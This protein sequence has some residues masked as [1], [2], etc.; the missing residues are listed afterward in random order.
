MQTNNYLDLL[1]SE[2]LERGRIQFFP[3][4]HHSPAAAVLIEQ[5]ILERSPEAILV[6][7][8]E[9]FNSELSELTLDHDFPIA[10]Y[11]YCRSR[12]ATSG[13]FYPFNEHSPE[14]VAIK[15]GLEIGS[16]VEFIDL[17]LH[18]FADICNH[19][20]RYSDGEINKSDLL[21]SIYGRFAVADFDALWDKLIE[22]DDRLNFEDY[23]RIAH[24]ICLNMRESVAL[25]QETTV[26]ETFMAA[27]IL[28]CLKTTRG[29]IL[30]ITGGFH[31]AGILQILRD[32]DTETTADSS[33]NLVETIPVLQSTEDLQ[34]GCTLTPFSDRRLDAYKGYEAGLPSPGFYFQAWQDRL[35]NKMKNTHSTLL[36][37]AVEALRAKKQLISTADVITAQSMASGLAALR[38]H[39]VVFR[40]DLMDGITSA[41]A[42]DELT[43]ED[44]HPLVNELRNIFRGSRQGK[45][46]SKTKLPPLTLAI[47]TIMEQHQ[48]TPTSSP[49]LF[50]LNLD[51]ETERCKSQI[52]HRLT[53]LNVAGISRRQFT[54]LAGDESGRVIEQWEIRQA[55]NFHA[56]CIEAAAWG[57]TIEEAVTNKIRERI[58]S[59]HS[60][61]DTV[62]ISLMQSC[63]MALTELSDELFEQMED[64]IY[65]DCSL[66]SVVSGLG[67]ILDLLY[68]QK[69]FAVKP[70]EAIQALLKLCFDRALWLLE[71]QGTSASEEFVG[72]IKLIVEIV[73][74]H[75]AKFKLDS[76]IV[77]N[78]LA[79]AR[80]Q[81]GC[82]AL[83][84]GALAGALW[85][86]EAPKDAQIAEGLLQFS[87]PE[88]IG[89]FVLGLLTL[90]G[91]LVH[92][93]FAIIETV[94]AIIEAYSDPDFLITVPS[95]R[96]AFS[97]YSPREKVLL[98][99]NLLKIQQISENRVEVNLEV[100]PE[101]IIKVM[102]VEEKAQAIINRY[103]LRQ[104]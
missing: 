34:Y 28:N 70:L 1:E 25:D 17:P 54:G 2:H 66:L 29:T 97:K 65:T 83:I 41:V 55:S 24:G 53:N 89:D 7:G 31:S 81:D 26:R 77:A 19:N 69:I 16:H 88:Q 72:G 56:S 103:G 82:S 93:D 100:D 74:F 23:M 9:N 64:I 85:Q 22:S 94:N 76:R 92:S 8:P 49:N 44:E 38:G 71:Y 73:Q 101:R 36:S 51:V 58:S 80:K 87:L 27:K 57:A 37:K 39:K 35:Q 60:N 90:A 99:Q 50:E 84:A 102:Q 95:L 32:S 43:F 86:L 63:L 75:T 40:Q 104:P 67:S 68:Y 59:S 79:R 46:S 12:H 6:E 48:L 3:V 91:N 47:Q 21:S 11:S 15:R 33:A 10:I 52:L 96:I 18:R 5:Y 13:V 62:A 30:V 20:H 45:L 14:Y 78:S 61:T 98:L 4:R 42:K